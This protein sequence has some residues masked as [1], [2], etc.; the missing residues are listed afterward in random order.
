VLQQYT[1]LSQLATSRGTQLWAIPSGRYIKG[2]GNEGDRA[3]DYGQIG[4]V[5]HRVVIQTQGACRIQHDPANPRHNVNFY[6]GAFDELNQQFTNAGVTQ[7]SRHWIDMLAVGA[8][9]DAFNNLTPEQSFECVKIAE[10]HGVHEHAPQ[11][12][13]NYT[14]AMVRLLQL[15]QAA[16]NSSPIRPM[17][18]RQNAL[19]WMR[20]LPM[21]AMAIPLLSGA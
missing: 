14:S 1:E 10:A 3:W 20:R 7:A 21:S 9:G 17:A 6:V 13:N 8:E 18:Q 12:G 2:F 5:V 16:L 19:A 4:A 11:W 15:R